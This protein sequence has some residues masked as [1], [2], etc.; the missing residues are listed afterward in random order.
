MRDKIPLRDEVSFLDSFEGYL[1]VLWRTITKMHAEQHFFVLHA[2]SLMSGTERVPPSAPAGTRHT[3]LV[4]VHESCEVFKY[5]TP[6][7]T[8]TMPTLEHL[9]DLLSWVQG[10]GK[11]RHFKALHFRSLFKC[12]WGLEREREMAILYVKRVGFRTFVASTVPRAT[13]VLNT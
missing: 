8:F 10:R 12:P 6:G 13:N 11:S 5:L 9:E 2:V 3:N 1:D 4:P 7:N